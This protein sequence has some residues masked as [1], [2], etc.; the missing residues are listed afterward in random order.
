MSEFLNIEEYRNVQVQVNAHLAQSSQH[1]TATLNLFKCI[2]SDALTTD[3]ITTDEGVDIASTHLNIEKHTQYTLVAD[4]KSYTQFNII[5]KAIHQ[6]RLDDARL[7]NAIWSTPLS[8]QDDPNHLPQK[9][10]NN[11]SHYA[12][13]RLNKDADEFDDSTTLEQPTMLYDI[14]ESLP[15]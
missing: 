10:I 3:H 13:R 15:D 6:G 11:L 4:S 1:G 2:L 5:N 8:Q 14:L 12:Q 9:V 7:L